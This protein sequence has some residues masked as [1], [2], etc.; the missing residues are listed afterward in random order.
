M[1]SRFHGND[2]IL[3]DFRF[4]FNVSSLYANCNC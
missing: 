3:L 2:N 4:A 1:D